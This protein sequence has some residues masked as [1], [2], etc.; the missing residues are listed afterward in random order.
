MLRGMGKYGVVA[1]RNG[2]RS[3][4]PKGGSAQ[5]NGSRAS[6]VYGGMKSRHEATA[7]I[8][9][10]GGGSAGQG[11]SG[12]GST[13]SASMGNYDKE[14]LTGFMQP[15]NEVAMRRMFRDI[16]SHDPVAGSAVD[17]MSE[18]PWSDFTLSGLPDQDMLRVFAKSME[19]IS[20]KTLLPEATREYQVLGAHVSAINFDDKDNALTSLMPQDID[21]CVVTPLPMYGRDPIIDVMIPKHVKQLIER[22]KQDKR[23]AQAFD[24]YGEDLLKMAQGD[25]FPLDPKYTVYLPRRTF[26]TSTVG[27]SYYQR[28]LPI[29]I[30]EKALLRGTIDLAY[31]RQKSILHLIVGD[32][33]WEPN[34]QE[35]TQIVNMFITA[36]VDPTGA[37]VATRPGIQTNEIRNGSD[38][39]RYDEIYDFVSSAKMRALGISEGFLSG[40]ASFNTMETSLSVFLEQI[41]SFRESMTRRLFYQKLFPLIAVSN[42]FKIEEKKR[43]E[44]RGTVHTRGRN[45]SSYAINI[46]AN[47][48]HVTFAGFQSRAEEEVD[49]T[50]YWM[51][52]LQ[53]HK[54]LKPEADSAYLE[55]LNTLAEKGMPVPL[56]MWA[57]ASGVSV[58]EVMSSLSE[59]VK[60]RKKIKKYQDA[61]PKSPQEEAGEMFGAQASLLDAIAPHRK[62]LVRAERTFGDFG[63]GEMRD[64]LTGKALSRKGVR[65]IEE[66][67]VKTGAAALASVAAKENAAT[68]AAHPAADRIFHY[69]KSKSSPTNPGTKAARSDVFGLTAA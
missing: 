18:M 22:A 17:M 37:V 60:L 38:F 14:I 3:I 19:A 39:W 30:L 23:I 42:D 50:E 63:T 12:Y 45:G 15:G 49:I 48:R 24:K 21:S 2:G 34:N 40:D 56:R 59:D 5:S 4:Q 1:D 65:V 61:L 13:S 53:W 68:K 41:R 58:P 46:G 7:N 51:P 27:T 11:T 28:I 55:I 64:P 32:E 43:L 31:R 66:R 36:D 54:G 62:P 47:P 67:M 6:A 29:W 44:T 20:I 57:A 33:E 9:M 35:L 26:A 10:P 69:F 16:Y 25:R 8:S 52:R